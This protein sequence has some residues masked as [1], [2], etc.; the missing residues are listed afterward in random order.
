MILKRIPA[1]L[2]VLS[3]A[4]CVYSSINSIH[5]KAAEASIPIGGFNVVHLINGEFNLERS[6]NAEG[7][8]GYATINNSAR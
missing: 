8:K 1:L 2:L 4:G 3:T 7:T 6:M 5:V